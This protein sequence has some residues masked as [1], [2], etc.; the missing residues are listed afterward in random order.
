MGATHKK[1]KKGE[2]GSRH[3]VGHLALATLY[4]QKRASVA[5]ATLPAIPPRQHVE[6][7]QSERD[8][9]DCSLKRAFIAAD[10]GLVAR[11]A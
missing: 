6:N 4:D 11:N 3:I 5:Q 1:N 2:D 9:R 10:R 7:E 8:Y